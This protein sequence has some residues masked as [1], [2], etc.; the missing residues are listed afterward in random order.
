MDC[1]C[2]HCGRKI[3][4]GKI[5]FDL[6]GFI[7]EQL[8]LATGYQGFDL[9]SDK[10][11]RVCGG[12]EKLFNSLSIE[13]HL[14]YNEEEIW[15]WP[16]KSDDHGRVVVMGMPYDRVTALFGNLD[17][18]NSTNVVKDAY[19]WIS[20]GKEILTAIRFPLILEKEG[21]GSIRF[22]LIRSTFNN[23]PII[24][25]RVCPVCGNTLSFWSG[26]YE[27]ICLGVLGGPR[28]SKTTTLTACANVFLKGFEGIT[29]QGSMVDEEY[30]K[31]SDAYLKKYRA[32]QSIEAT[33]QRGGKN[34]VPRV[35]FFV[36]IRDKHTNMLIKE[37]TLT[38][39]DLPGEL[40]NE[41]GINDEFYARYS[42][43]YENVDF[44]WYCTDPGELLQL[45]EVAENSEKVQE[46]GY[47]GRER[48]M[49]TEE[50]CTNMTR[51]ASIFN[52]ENKKVPVAY[53]LGK[54]DTTLIS[55][56]ER[57]QYHLYSPNLIGYAA[58]KGAFDIQHFH[59]ESSLVSE[60]MIERNPI[61]INTFN[62]NFPDHCYFAVSAYGFAPSKAGNAEL[63]PFN[64]AV[65]FMWMLALKSCYPI[66][67]VV[68]RRGLGG[69]KYSR[70]PYYLKNASKNEKEKDY[71]NLFLRGQY[72]E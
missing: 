14:I 22:N 20:Q 15:N 71:Y 44:L 6:T 54:T 7:K 25:G 48:I 51:V 29:W 42:H 68:A 37:M 28:V 56:M 46:L 21:R 3:E 36:T 34:N 31:F 27:E 72:L 4:D 17:G 38:F 43:F 8:L 33:V 58:G 63:R 64:V 55:N 57:D 61:L 40:N 11:T 9:S 39:V 1:V 50:I 60:Y 59:G 66:I 65:P 70:V 47:G 52:R 53:I 2:P 49:S 67:K 35:S 30:R 45:T 16:L 13:K 23:R 5:G 12:I 10:K 26:R 24:K 41:E 32:G 62:S 69:V 18:E 19:E